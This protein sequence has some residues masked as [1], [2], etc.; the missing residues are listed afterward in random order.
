MPEL[1]PSAEAA[2]VRSLAERLAELAGEIEQSGGER[3]EVDRVVAELRSIQNQVYGR[4]KRAPSGMGGKPTILAYLLERV[5]EVVYG[6]E[7]AAITGIGE[8]PRR[9]RELRV[10]DGYPIEE[11]G[12]SSYRLES[13]EPDFTK[14]SAWALENAI[15]RRPGSGSS[16]I[17]AF[18]A[19]NVGNV[20]TRK[21]I[22]Y[23]SKIG[24]AAR[25]VRELRDE[26]GWPINSHIDD[27][28]LRP[29]EYRLTS[30]EPE[31]ILDARQ[32]SYPENLRRR[33]F[34]RD[35]YTCRRCGRNR[36]AAEAAGDTRFYLEVHHKVAITDER[37]TLSKVELNDLDNL[38][39]L[40]HSCHREETA[41]LHRQRRQRR[42]SNPNGV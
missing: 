33:V 20:V 29:G 1:E 37:E 26:R 42:E 25:R 38:E 16:R 14:A 10:Q 27:S 8:W 31:D 2:R 40:C 41:K 18:F 30:L 6:E 17:A 9:V 22:D 15:R 21:Q 11:L 3:E 28:E 7:L 36:A 19:A 13:L 5:G 4:R 39:T 12:S 23:V 35:R 24:S 34:E 32:R